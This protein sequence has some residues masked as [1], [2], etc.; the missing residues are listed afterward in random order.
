MNSFKEFWS[1]KIT[2]VNQT[3]IPASLH[4][5]G[6]VAVN[7]NNGSVISYGKS[8]AN[9]GAAYTATQESI[10][11]QGSMIAL[12]QSQVNA[13]QQYCMALQSQPPTPIYAQQFQLRAPNNQRRLLHCTGSGRCRGYQNPGYQQPTGA[14]PMRAPMPYKRFKNWHYC[15][16]HR[17]NVNDT[18]MSATCPKPS[19]L[20]NWQASCTNMM[21]GSTAG[22][23][24]TI[25]PSAAGHA[26]LVARAPQIQ[27]P[28]TL[29]AWQ[30]PLPPVNFMQLMAAM[31]PLVPYQAIY[32]MGQQP[33]NVAPPLPPSAGAMMHYY[34]P[35]PQQLAYQHPPPF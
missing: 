21:G 20:H 18:H 15:H 13:M 26:P 3:A 17:G 6:M 14:P 10:K 12:L 4:G 29:V 22:M 28:P 11:T 25:L 5:Y 7:D 31:H 2:L 27:R 23:H 32:H 24:K 9:F 34:A 30:P 8:I 33:T 35:F 16:T 1:S 19:P